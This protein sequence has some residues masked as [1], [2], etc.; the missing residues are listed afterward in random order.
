LKTVV[1]LLEK[2]LKSF[3][4]VEETVERNVMCV[5]KTVGTIVRLLT[6]CSNTFGSVAKTLERT[7]G[8]LKHL[9]KN[10]LVC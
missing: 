9:L 8:L 1:G 10:D 6:K 5:G 2:L 7:M 3:W 4:S